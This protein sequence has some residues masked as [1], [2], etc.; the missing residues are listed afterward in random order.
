[1]IAAVATPRLLFGLSMVKPAENGWIDS[2]MRAQ[3]LEN[4][5]PVL[6]WLIF[7]DALHSRNLMPQ[8][9]LIAFQWQGRAAGYKAALTRFAG[10]VFGCD[11]LRRPP[12]ATVIA[13]GL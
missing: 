7:F 13:A 6:R 12:G 3:A 2:Q 10:V 5:R 9:E 8:P 4:F 11:Q 1:V